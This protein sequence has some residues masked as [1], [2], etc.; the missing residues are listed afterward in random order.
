MAFSPTEKKWKTSRLNYGD[1]KLYFSRKMCFEWLVGC[2]QI[3]ILRVSA[4]TGISKMSVFYCFLLFIL[5]P[6]RRMVCKG[7]IK[8]T[9]THNHSAPCLEGDCVFGTAA[10]CAKS[11]IKIASDNETLRSK[12]MKIECRS[13]SSSH[14]G[15]FWGNEQFMKFPPPSSHTISVRNVFI[16]IFVNKHEK[17]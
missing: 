2:K 7:V 9:R 10:V 13:F 17:N 6:F 11:A 15:K 1:E 4:I 16:F 12:K 3:P 8:A 5:I 14:R